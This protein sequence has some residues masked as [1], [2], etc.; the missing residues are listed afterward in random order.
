M[1]CLLL[2]PFSSCL[3]LSLSFSSSPRLS[4]FTLQSRERSRKDLYQDGLLELASQNPAYRVVIVGHSLG[5]GTASVLATVLLHDDQFAPF[6]ERLRCFAYAPPLVM[7]PALCTRPIVVDA[8]TSLVYRHDIVCRLSMAT[9]LRLR[10]QLEQCFENVAPKS[11]KWKIMWNAVQRK[12]SKNWSVISGTPLDWDKLGKEVLIDPE[13]KVAEV[14]I[15]I[16]SDNKEAEATYMAGRLYHMMPRHG[17][18]TDG[19]N[20]IVVYPASQETFQE[21]SVK[22]SMFLNHMPYLYTLKNLQLP[23]G[24]QN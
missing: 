8:I 17:V 5:A 16:V 13:V 20:G 4:S 21:I 22:S 1:F 23:A 7:S 10:N 3:L 11:H 6:R 18:R 19:P 15:T 12:H 2:S 24:M 14:P 9:L